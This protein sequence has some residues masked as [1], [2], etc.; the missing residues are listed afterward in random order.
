MTD[1]AVRC[2][3]ALD[4]AGQ[5]ESAAPSEEAGAGRPLADRLVTLRRCRVARGA[6]FEEV[7][8]LQEAIEAVGETAALRAQ[9]EQLLDERD[10]HR[11]SPAD[12][13]LW[14]L[15]RLAR[16]ATRTDSTSKATRAARDELVA[17][18]LSL[19]PLEANRD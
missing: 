14:E 18:A 1:D 2:L 11:F 12:P 16:E 8:D 6:S 15:H 4:T 3:L 19:F 7:S 17:L 13:R 9:V 10:N 5:G